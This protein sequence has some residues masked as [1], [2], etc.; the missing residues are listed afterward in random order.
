MSAPSFAS[1]T[2]RSR[3]F[4]R[5]YRVE[6]CRKKKRRKTHNTLL[7]TLSWAIE[8]NTPHK[9][10]LLTLIF[11]FFNIHDDIPPPFSPPSHYPRLANVYS[12]VQP[13]STNFSIIANFSFLFFFAFSHF[14]FFSS[15]SHPQINFSTS[16]H[17]D[18]GER[19]LVH[20]TTSN[21]NKHNKA[22]KTFPQIMD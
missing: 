20:A 14:P 1:P 9:R 10:P 15:F 16:I 12:N 22:T 4:P 2:R 5:S 6:I 3:S 19:D 17:V 18:K 11:A 13:A 7:C 21:I 8:I